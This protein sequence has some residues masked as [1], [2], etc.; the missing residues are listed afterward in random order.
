MSPEIVAALIGAAGGIVVTVLNNRSALKRE[1]LARR[2][3]Q[4]GRQAGNVFALVLFLIAGGLVYK[5]WTTKTEATAT[6]PAAD[7][8]VA[9]ESPLVSTA[10]AATPTGSSAPAELAATCPDR[11]EFEA[12]KAAN[13]ANPAN[14]FNFDEL[15]ADK[16]ALVLQMVITD[17]T[18]FVVSIC[19]DGPESFW[20]F[21][22]PEI[23]KG[24]LVAR[25]LRTESGFE[26]EY[27]TG[28]YTLDSSGGW[29]SETTGTT[30][31]FRLNAVR[32]VE[33]D[34]MPEALKALPG[35]A[36]T[37][38]AVIAWNP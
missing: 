8:P 21:G 33:P 18:N 19:T 20:W 15:P 5:V 17:K 9:S 30:L 3:S 28:H 26:S 36:C 37:E 10:N 27:H 6:A 25:A 29:F 14:P 23:K 16:S 38:S 12:A 13:P 1:R 2:A 35:P 7:S 11:A 22:H 24:G 31:P 34:E 32:C 4:Q